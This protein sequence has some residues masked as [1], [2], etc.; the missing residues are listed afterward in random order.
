MQRQLRADNNNNRGGNN[1]VIIM[2]TEIVAIT[3]GGNDNNG[4]RGGRGSGGPTGVKKASGP[5]AAS[6]AIPIM[7]IEANAPY[8]PSNLTMVL[9]SGA[10]APSMSGVSQELDPARII[11][12][13]QL[14]FVSEA[15]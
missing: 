11:E 2:V 14:L 8:S 15:Q 4:G 7:T 10:A 13:N 6:A 1:D 9:P 3:V 12:E 5:T